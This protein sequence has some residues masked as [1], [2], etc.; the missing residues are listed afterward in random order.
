MNKITKFLI[1]FLF[2]F[3]QHITFSQS[4][5]EQIKNLAARLDS[6]KEIIS[7]ERLEFLAKK[8]ELEKNNLNSKHSYI[9][10][11][12]KDIDIKNDLQNLNQQNENLGNENLKIKFK[13]K[14]LEDSIQSII[15][16]QPIKFIE[17][18]I[19]NKSEKEL[20]KLMKISSSDLGD[21]F[22]EWK[23]NSY[24]EFNE[25]PTMSIIGKQ[26][27]HIYGKNYCIVILEVYNQNLHD[28]SE[29]TSFIGLL[30]ENNGYWNLSKK[31]NSNFG[32]RMGN[33]SKF[34]KI[35]LMGNKTLTVEL[36]NYESAQGTAYENRKIYALINNEFIQVYE[37]LKHYDECGVN[38]NCN[39][40]DIE[41]KFL[42]IDSDYYNLE[43][44]EKK[45]GLK[46]KTK[47]LKFNEN[48]MKYE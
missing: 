3:I 34:E 17:S 9:K 43:I 38:N 41:V 32:G 37:G 46:L 45:Q 30:E 6:L 48:K 16:N 25:P 21:E 31:I 28:S 36:S 13:L 42:K 33:P 10:L 39:S 44:K 5:K 7:T 26:L 14:L 27:F 11:Q 1:T 47:I 40:L 4:K 19:L 35:S 24:E 20:I 2:I 15:N 22:K 8:N 29:G 23:G 18:N 12:K